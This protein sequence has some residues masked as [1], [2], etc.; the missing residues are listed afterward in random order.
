MQLRPLAIGLKELYAVAHY[1]CMS[2]GFDAED[3]D[4][5]SC[6]TKPTLILTAS[7]THNLH[8]RYEQAYPV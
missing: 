2:Q 8:A 4:D 3:I 7:H 6:A 5:D 1:R